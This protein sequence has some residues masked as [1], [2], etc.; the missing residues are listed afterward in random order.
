MSASATSNINIVIKEDGSRVVKRNLEDLGQSAEGASEQIELV[1]KAIEGIVAAESVRAITEMI[2][3]YQELHNQLIGVTSGQ[4]NLNAVFDKL[5]QV[6]E[7][8]HSSIKDNVDEYQTLAQATHDLGLS[9]KQI[10]DFQTQLNQA[11]RLS[12]G[13]SEAAASAVDMLA[14]GLSTGRLEGAA[15]TRTLQQVPAVGD[16][17]AKSLGVTRGALKDMAD[18]GDLSAKQ[19]VDAFAKAAPALQAQFDKLTPS[20]GEAFDELKQQLMLS[21]GAFSDSTGAGN[22]FADTIKSITEFVKDLTPGFIDF[23]HALTGTL[24]PST[25]LST[26]MKVFASILTVVVGA[27]QLVVSEIKDGVVNSFKTWGDLLGGLGAAIAAWVEGVIDEFT[28]IVNGVGA[29]PDAI[30]KASKGDFTAAGQELAGAFQK[31]WD[32]AGADFD[33]SASIL[34]DTFDH[35]ADNVGKSWDDTMNDF[36]KTGANTWDKLNKIWDEGARSLQK[37]QDV[38]TVSTKAGPNVTTQYSAQEIQATTKALQQLLSQFSAVNGAALQLS[39]GEELLIK[40]QKEGIITKAQ[41]GQYLTDLVKHYQDLLDPVGAYSR[42][43]DQ[44]TGLLKFSSDQRAIETTLLQKEVE[45]R[46]KGIPVTQAQTDALRAQLQAQQDLQKITAAQD[47]IQQGSASQQTKNQTAQLT[48]AANLLKNSNS[49]VNKNDVTN[50]LSQQNPDLFANT[51]EQFDAQTAKYQQLYATIDAMRQKDLISE[52]TAQAMKVKV[53]SQSQASQLNV[54][55]QFFGDLSALTHSSNTKIAAVGKAAAV[56]QA[57]INTY[58]AA[59]AAYASLAAIPI[60]GPALGAAAAA[61]A[62][63]AGLANIAKIE[64]APTGFMTGGSFTVPGATGGPD[65][66]MVAFRATPGERVSV[67]TP[68]QVRKGD[69]TGGGSAANAPAPQVNQRIINVLDPGMV[70]DYLA[71]PE[72]ETALVNVMRRNA[73]TVRSIAKSG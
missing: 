73:D 27:I 67:A 52:Q 72:G 62:I 24:D 68:A 5:T 33:R 30:K 17:L 45:W 31:P 50:A 15:F 36:T 34:S 70:G 29:I 16:I 26:G 1:Q 6:A 57:T 12:T 28:A 40:A 20:I 66:Q 19:L 58:T 51:Q 23:G 10:I 42:Q 54:A 21:V 25:E 47:A 55:S 14:R 46:Q 22:L 37:K 48:G 7:S 60:Y 64:S 59:T 49:G 13:S 38:G 56:A 9:Q 61:A 43:I 44:Q 18:T 2:N 3:Q 53:W 4:A 63:V 41:E 65:S 32:D 8:T 69:P 35:L 39:Q 71:T 11:T